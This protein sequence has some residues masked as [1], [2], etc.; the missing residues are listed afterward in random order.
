[1]TLEEIL[2]AIDAL[3]EE[4]KAKVKAK[5][6]DLDKAEDER[7]IDKIEEDKASNPEVADEKKEEVKEESDEIGKTVDELKE[8]VTVDTDKEEEDQ[9]VEIPEETEEVEEEKT[10]EVPTDELAP[11]N[12]DFNEEPM[13]EEN[14]EEVVEEEGEK[15]VTD[16]SAE[17]N[18]AEMVH[19]LTDRLAQIEEQLNGMLEVKAKLEEM[20]RKKDQA[21]GYESKIP[22]AKKDYSSMTANEL[23]NQLAVNI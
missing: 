2:K 15:T 9:E 20:S 22:G 8:E 23:K 10:E 4:D 3:P 13:T 18:L 17:E 11:E 5:V 6:Q 16:E 12:A 1:M 14:A 19:G 21:F 7:E